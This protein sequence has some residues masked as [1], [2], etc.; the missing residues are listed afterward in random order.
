M[1]HND[2]GRIAFSKNIVIYVFSIT[3]KS[4]F[5]IKPLHL[6]QVQTGEL[7]VVV[8]HWHLAALDGSGLLHRLL[9]FIYVFI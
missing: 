2:Q 6:S 1:I 8:L 9:T 3:S 5:L 4:Q 7:G